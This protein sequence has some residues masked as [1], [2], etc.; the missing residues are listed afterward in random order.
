MIR[1]I[2]FFSLFASVS[3]VAV[4]TVPVGEVV[5]FKNCDFISEQLIKFDFSIEPDAANVLYGVYKGGVKKVLFSVKKPNL[6]QL[7]GAVRLQKKKEFDSI[8]SWLVLE[9]DL[10]GSYESH[11]IYLPLGVEVESK[12]IGFN[13]GKI[14]NV[15]LDYVPK[16]REKVFVLSVKNNTTNTFISLM[17]LEEKL[18]SACGG[19]EKLPAWYIPGRAY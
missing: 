15:F 19:I 16:I 6:K 14:V 2:L 8:G 17:E 7:N 4:E 3:A 18:L 5:P 10:G 11:L 13:N 1:I 9:E 12:E